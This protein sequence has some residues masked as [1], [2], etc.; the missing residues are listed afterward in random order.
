MIFP[1]VLEGPHAC[2]NHLLLLLL[3]LLLFMK[4]KGY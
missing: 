3:L 1:T 4:G 2:K